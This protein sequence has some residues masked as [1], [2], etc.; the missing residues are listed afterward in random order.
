MSLKAL[1]NNPNVGNLTKWELPVLELSVFPAIGARTGINRDLHEHLHDLF[2]NFDLKNE[3]SK[4]YLQF[5]D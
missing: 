5:R 2:I 3:R 4:L 1:F